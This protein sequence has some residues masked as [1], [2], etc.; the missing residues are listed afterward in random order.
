MIRVMNLQVGDRFS[1]SGR[2]VEVTGKPRRAW[3]KCYVPGIS[4]TIEGVPQPFPAKMG[5][6]MRAGQ[7]GEYVF[8]DNDIV[9]YVERHGA[10]LQDMGVM[11]HECGLWLYPTIYGD[12]VFGF[13]PL[14]GKQNA[15]QPP[16]ERH[17]SKGPLGESNL[18]DDKQGAR[19]GLDGPSLGGIEE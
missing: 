2:E 17:I 8:H 19:Q 10:T 16:S 14:H 1:W 4:H 18:Q 6:Q 15:T 13:C 7:Y 9:P 12:L 5:P 3:G 11:C